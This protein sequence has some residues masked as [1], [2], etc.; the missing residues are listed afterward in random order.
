MI[1]CRLV[2]EGRSFSPVHDGIVLLR[3]MQYFFL[4]GSRSAKERI[5][6]ATNGQPRAL[7]VG[8]GTKE[9]GRVPKATSIGLHI[10]GGNTYITSIVPPAFKSIGFAKL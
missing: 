9:V 1:D 2:G 5:L 3:P 10:R 6:L 4:V 8:C 7:P